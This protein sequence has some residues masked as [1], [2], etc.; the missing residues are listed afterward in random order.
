MTV[1]AF[2]KKASCPSTWGNWFNEVTLLNMTVVSLTNLYAAALK[3]RLCYTRQWVRMNHQRKLER[4]TKANSP[5]SQSRTRCDH[6][7][8]AETLKLS[9]TQNSF[10]GS[11]FNYRTDLIRMGLLQLMAWVAALVPDKEGCC[12]WQSNK[13]IILNKNDSVF[14][15]G[16]S[17]S[18]QRCIFT[19]HWW[20]LNVSSN[21][22][23]NRYRQRVYLS[24]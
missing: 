4:W 18:V 14:T 10:P 22:Y 13:K 8:N 12:V 9:Q 15:T 19:V 5:V 7:K 24:L 17:A 2:V 16:M 11:N 20:N 23:R 6:Y 21:L 3:R 1:T